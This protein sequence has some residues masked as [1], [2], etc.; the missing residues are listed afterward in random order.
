MDQQT[1]LFKIYNIDRHV[2]KLVDELNR[3]NEKDYDD[4]KK[5]LDDL[6]TELNHLI[7][8]Y[9]HEYNEVLHLFIKDYN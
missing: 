6:I 4:I 3:C 2:E 7:P 5:E 1:L 9:E 8:S